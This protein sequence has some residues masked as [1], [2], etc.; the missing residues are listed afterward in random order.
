MIRIRRS[1]SFLALAAALSACAS[2]GEGSNGPWIPGNPALNSVPSI[3]AAP[4]RDTTVVF[5]Q[6]E[7]QGMPGVHIFARNDR[8]VPMR[9]TKLSV[10]ECENIEGGCIEWDPETVLEP[11]DRKRLYTIIPMNM[12]R[13]YRFRWRAFY[14]GVQPVR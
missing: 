12:S 10:Y 2:T 14:A 3:P 5:W 1:T 11:G 8:P 9:V 13:A 7:L 6:E 4:R